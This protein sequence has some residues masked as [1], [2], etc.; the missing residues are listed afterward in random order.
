MHVVNEVA[1]VHLKL[2]IILKSKSACIA[3]KTY[4][5]RKPNKD[6]PVMQVSPGQSEGV[7]F[8][9]SGHEI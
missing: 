7:T 9:V 8:S 1:S 5:G 6:E 3:S 2:N 4:V